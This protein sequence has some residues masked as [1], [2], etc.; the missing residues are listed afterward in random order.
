MVHASGLHFK[1]GNKKRVLYADSDARPVLAAQL[2]AEDT[3]HECKLS[4][5]VKAN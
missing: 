3:W 4:R 1:S 2:Y 5:A